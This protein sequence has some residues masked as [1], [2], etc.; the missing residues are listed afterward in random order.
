MNKAYNNP[1]ADIGKIKDYLL[2]LFQN[3]TDMSRLVTQYFGMPYIAGSITDNGCAIFIDTRLIKLESQ[4]VKEVG[5]DIHIVC[6]KD[7]IALSEEDKAYYNSLDI[8]G[9]RVD[10]A[11]QLINAVIMNPKIM[12]EIKQNY[13]ISDMTFIPEKPV[14]RLIS[15]TDFCGKQMSYTYQSFYK[16]T[17]R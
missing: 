2:S 12:N 5:V 13:A 14:K 3:N 11:A 8:Y 1:L 15:E 9:N 7:S 10:C 4:R 16:R 6:H 17:A